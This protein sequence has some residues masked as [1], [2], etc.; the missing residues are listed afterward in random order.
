MK[1]NWGNY[2]LRR[3]ISILKKKQYSPRHSHYCTAHV[4]LCCSYTRWQ[5][6]N[7]VNLEMFNSNR[8]VLPI[9]DQP[10]CG[11]HLSLPL[12]TISNNN[13]NGWFE[14]YGVFWRCII[15]CPWLTFAVTIS[16]SQTEIWSLIWIYE[17]F[18]Y[19]WMIVSEVEG[20]SFVTWQALFVYGAFLRCF[21]V[22]GWK[23]HHLLPLLTIV[24]LWKY[25]F[26]Q[27]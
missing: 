27:C 16:W 11:G 2:S 13:F 21:K 26:R 17:L 10:F 3:N 6:L 25:H 1:K 9:L 12:V 20:A 4:H 7:I 8:G 14:F 18:Y 15:G 23:V 24:T 5:G 19:G 22:R